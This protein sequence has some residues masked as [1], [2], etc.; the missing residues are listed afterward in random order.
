MPFLMP[1]L[2]TNYQVVLKLIYD[3]ARLKIIPKEYI[4]AVLKWIKN[5]L[6][7]NIAPTDEDNFFIDNMGSII[8][9]LGVALLLLILIFLI[10][11]LAMKF[12]K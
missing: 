5:N 12:K 9:C 6:K 3:V 8:M 11:F 10:R 2:P 1:T 7:I 4:D